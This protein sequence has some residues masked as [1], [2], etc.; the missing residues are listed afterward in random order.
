[1]SIKPTVLALLGSGLLAVCFASLPSGATSLPA[2]AGATAVK[3]DGLAQ[4][5]HWRRWHHN[6]HGPYLRFR[7]YPRYYRYYYNPCGTRWSCWWRHGHR[8]CGWV[9]TCYRRYY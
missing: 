9:N 4:P 7:V 6:H 2:V 3:A 1:M 8:H 5:V